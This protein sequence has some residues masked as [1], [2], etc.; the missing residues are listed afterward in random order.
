MPVDSEIH[1]LITAVEG[2]T[3]LAAAGQIAAGYALLLAGFRR[4][5]GIRDAGQPGDELLVR[6]YGLAM[7]NYTDAYGVPLT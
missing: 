2:A 4:A 5:E 3:T 1:R 6:R 7:Q